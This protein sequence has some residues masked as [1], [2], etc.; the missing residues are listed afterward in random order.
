MGFRMRKSFTVPGVRLNVSKSGLDASFG[1]KHGRY[2][3]HSS[4]RRTVSAGTG[5]PGVYSKE[6]RRGKALRQSRAGA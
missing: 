4:G 3:V 6:R 2:S 1:G 5:I